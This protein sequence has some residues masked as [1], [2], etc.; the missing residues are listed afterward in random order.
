MVKSSK[1]G[2]FVSDEQ[3]IKSTTVSSPSYHLNLFPKH[4][5]SEEHHMINQ[6]H[7]MINQEHSM[8]P[9][10]INKQ[11]GSSKSKEKKSKKGGNSHIPHE[12]FE[13]MDYQNDHLTYHPSHHNSHHPRH[14]EINDSIDNLTYHPSHKGGSKKTK[15]N[16]SKK[17]GNSH[18]PHE[19]FEHMDYQNDHLTYH[20]P[21]HNSHHSPHHNSHHPPNENLTYHPL[22]KG[23]SRKTKEN[24]SKKGGNLLIPRE[25]FEHMDDNFLD[26]INHRPNHNSHKMHNL[27]GGNP[28]VS[29]YASISGEENNMGDVSDNWGSARHENT[30]ITPNSDWS[31][32]LNQNAG[33]TTQ[34]GGVKSLKKKTDKSI[35]K[36]SDK[37]IK[38]K[39]LKKKSVKKGGSDIDYAKISG[40]AI[41]SKYEWAKS[42]NENVYPPSDMDIIY[43]EQI[44]SAKST[45]KKRTVKPKSDK[46]KVVKPKSDKKKVVKPKSDKKKKE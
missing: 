28:F 7:H 23:G 1:K 24:K 21:H 15:E 5:V 32:A 44:G 36:K 18:I 4:N 42:V 8:K 41:N 27:K 46:K 3:H 29:D 14:H 12:E 17:G 37:T 25:E 33:I 20:P 16:K 43:H 2:G 30:I 35:K 19:E 11:H 38:K 45:I 34:M 31:S 9:M 22:H 40:N 39:T 13:H 6:E 26:P 10:L